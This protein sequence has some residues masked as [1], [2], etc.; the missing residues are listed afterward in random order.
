MKIKVTNATYREDLRPGFVLDISSCDGKEVFVG[1]IIGDNNDIYK[2]INLENGK[3]L[4]DSSG[5]TIFGIN[6]IESLMD[7]LYYEDYAI[8]YIY[9]QSKIQLNVIK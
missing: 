4:K 6:S 5:N 1:M 7:S 9:D 2:I 3:T 8:S